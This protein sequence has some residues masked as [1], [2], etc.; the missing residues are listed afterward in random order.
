MGVNIDWDNYRYKDRQRE[1]RRQELLQENAEAG[2]AQQNGKKR[3]ASESVAWSHNA[4]MR[5]KK[6]KRREQKNTRKDRS[7]WDNMADEERQKILE[8]ERMVEE[9]RAKNEHQRAL[10]RAGK[11]EAEAVNGNGGDEEAFEGFD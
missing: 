5:E 4:E 6:M 8:T 7:R 2:P 11:T 9:I 1:K 3:P 10:K